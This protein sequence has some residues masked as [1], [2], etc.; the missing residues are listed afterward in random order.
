MGLPVEINPLFVSSTGGYQVG[1][2]L[3]FRASAS[4]YLSRTIGTP[5]TTTNT[6]SA[7]VKRGDINTAYRPILMCT[8]NN[9]GINYQLPGTSANDTIQILDNGT[10]L[11]ATSAVYRAP[12]AWYHVVV[13]WDSTNATSTDRVR[14][15]VNGFRVTAFGTTNYPVQNSAFSLFS[16]SNPWQIGSRQFPGA[17]YFDGYMAEINYIDGQALTASSFGAYDTNGVWQPIK[18]TGTYGTNGFYLPF[19]NTTSTSTLVAD[20]SGNGNNW[21]PNNISLTAGTTYDSMIDSPTVSASSSNYPVMNILDKGAN[22]SLSNANLQLSITAGGN[23]CLRCTMTIPSTGKWYWETTCSAIGSGA[24]VGIADAFTALS[25]GGAITGVLYQ[26]GGNKCINSWSTTAYGSTYTTNDIIGIAVDADA[27][28]I[29]FYKNNVSQG[30]ANTGMNFATTSYFPFLQT[31]TAG[32]SWT[33]NFGQ[34]P[35]SYTPPT[36]FNALNTYNLPAATIKNGAQYM[37]A[38]TYTG[39]GS[40]LAVLNSANTAIGTTF[41]P[42]FVWIKSRSNILGHELFDVLRGVNQVLYSNATNAETNSGTMSAFNSNGFTAVY[43][44]ADISTN[45][46]GYTYVGWQWKAGGTGVTNTSGSITST[47]SANTTAGFSVV[48]YTGTGANATVGHGLGV[49]PSMV[50]VKQRSGVNA[51][52]VYH[53]SLVSATNYVLLNQTDASNPAATVWNSTA[54]TSSV[55]SIGTAVGV[56]TSGQTY[57]AYCF[58]AVKGYSAFGSYTGNGSA[59][60]AFVYTGFRPRWVMFKRTDITSNWLIIDS[61]RG[62]YNSDQNRLFPNLSSAED[63]SENFDLLS[64]GFKLRDSTGTFNASGGTYIYAAFAENP[65]N[66]SRAR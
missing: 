11:L 3:R 60:G 46:S 23:D 28:T 45:N 53:S 10:T 7:W 62:T 30:T 36:G 34:R 25:S 55:F 50:I 61:S 64:N 21:T 33:I 8:N 58:A 32:G 63:T 56:N 38:T 52:P 13:V 19:S 26:S 5:S 49:A 42:D 44:A 20:A 18:Y 51:W 16:A 39:N 43:Q 40:T 27:G 31:T 14:L 15:Y 2:S 41:Q 35:F 17:L 37:A 9:S 4:A 29:A 24:N 12:S 1:R 54:P 57:V 47:V 65:F 22:L 48:T 6:F 66:S 59:D